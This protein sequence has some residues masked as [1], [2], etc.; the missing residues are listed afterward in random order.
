MPA[1]PRQVSQILNQRP[2]LQHLLAEIRHQQQ[3]LHLIQ[4]K[5]PT[6]IASHC[7]AAHIQDAQLCISVD[8]PV[9]ASQLRFRTP[10]LLGELRRQMPGI[11]NV[12]VRVVPPNVTTVARSNTKK[13]PRHACS[14]ATIQQIQTTAE[15]TDEANLSAALKRLAATMRISGNISS[16]SL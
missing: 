5:L 7:L 3:L 14:E 4:H 15:Y 9:W 13:V 11:A 16:P 10:E 2:S 12:K 1:N 8:S 6:K